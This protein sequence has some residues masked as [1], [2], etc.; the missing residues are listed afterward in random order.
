MIKKHTTSSQRVTSD[1]T[2]G[3]A[4]KRYPS[5]AE[6]L[7]DHGIHCVGCGA[8]N[9]ETIHQGLSAH[10]LSPER[11]DEI[12]QEINEGLPEEFGSDESVT[13]TKLAIDKLKQTLKDKNKEDMALRIVVQAGG[14]SG[15]SYGFE[16]TKEATEGDLV[17]EFEGARFL[18]AQ[19]SIEDVRGA[20][21]DYV[22]TLQGAG[23]T[24][25]NP[26]AKKTC[27]CGKSFSS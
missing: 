15:K 7:M 6:I 5:V 19:E 24:I 2:I 4:V 23:F 17:L 27:G 11:V 10:G 20:K 14:C 22:D 1:M 21:I 18:V 16:L 25:V 12:V 8:A 3:D 26:N 13:I 9:Y